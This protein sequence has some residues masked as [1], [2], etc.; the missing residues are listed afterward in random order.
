MGQRNGLTGKRMGAVAQELYAPLGD[1]GMAHLRRIAGLRLEVRVYRAAGGHQ[2]GRRECRR[3]GIAVIAPAR[4]G[5]FA[6]LDA[7]H[8]L[9]TGAHEQDAAVCRA[10]QRG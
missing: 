4:P 1:E 9:A 7:M 10:A 2:D 3:F 6:H 8:G 5:T